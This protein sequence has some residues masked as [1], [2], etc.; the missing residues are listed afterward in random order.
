M[1]IPD[2]IRL[3]FASLGCPVSYGAVIKIWRD[4]SS[5]GT[6][7]GIGS[8]SSGMWH[9]GI[10]CPD[11]VIHFCR[12][13]STPRIRL[14]TLEEFMLRSDKYQVHGKFVLGEDPYSIVVERAREELAKENRGEA[15]PY[16]FFKYNCEHFAR[17][18][19]TGD[20]YCFSEQVNDMKDGLLFHAILPVF[21]GIITCGVNT[22]R[23]LPVLAAIA[24]FLAVL[25]SF[26]MIQP[27]IQSIKHTK[28]VRLFGVVQSF[29]T[30]MSVITAL[31]SILPSKLVALF[32]IPRLYHLSPLKRRGMSAYFDFCVGLN[33]FFVFFVKG[34][35]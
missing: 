33:V 14:T 5:L 29:A 13:G 23:I 35:R 11:G 20:S 24:V 7:R 17:Y 1:I 22:S 3:Y 26:I 9:F 25:I 2:P 34:I 6:T 19:A 18:C 27:S 28:W 15:R 32:L 8:V 30:G 21:C 4:K 31:F 10:L 12:R 16:S